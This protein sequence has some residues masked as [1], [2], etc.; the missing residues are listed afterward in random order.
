MKRLA[1]FLLIIC[2]FAYHGAVNGQGTMRDREGNNYKTTVISNH[3]WMAE[4]LNVAHYRNGDLIPEARNAAE[5]ARYGEAGTGCWCYYE[6]NP[7]NGHK[8]G[9]LYNWFAVNDKRGLAPAGWHVPTDLDWLVF[10]DIPGTGTWP[11]IGM[12]S[13]RG[14]GAGSSTE[15]NGT[16][17]TGFNGLPGGSL[18]VGE[19]N[20]IGL[21]G[22]WWCSTESEQSFARIRSLACNSDDLWLHTSMKQCGHS[23]RCVRN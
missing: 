7:A 14:W 8:Y 13:V 4:N 1:A 12:K 19:F 15:C 9:K 23:V 20:G 2:I 16:N 18:E 5:W 17:T 11:G 10:T 21:I 6:F 3:V 22:R